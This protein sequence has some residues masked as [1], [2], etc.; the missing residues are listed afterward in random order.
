MLDGAGFAI[1]ELH[2]DLRLLFAFAGC[3]AAFRARRFF[4]LARAFAALV[5]GVERFLHAH[6]GRSAAYIASIGLN[7]LTIPLRVVEVMVCLHEVVDGEVI[8]AV[9]EARAAADD[10]LEFDHRVN[11]AHQHDVADVTGVYAGG[12]LL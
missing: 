8:F 1:G 4:T 11:R 12:E 10:L 7:R 3:L 6:A 2:L 9:V 5:T